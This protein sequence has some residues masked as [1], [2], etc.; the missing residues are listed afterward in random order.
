[1]KS[2]M[3]NRWFAVQIQ[4]V[5]KH[6]SVYFKQLTAFSGGTMGQ[7]LFFFR[8]GRGELPRVI[9]LIFCFQPAK[10]SLSLK[11]Y[12]W[13]NTRGIILVD[14]GVCQ[15]DFGAC[16]KDFGAF[17]CSL[18]LINED[19]LRFLCGPQSQW[20][21]QSKPPVSLDEILFLLPLEVGGQGVIA[22]CF[23]AGVN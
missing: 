11:C 14:F 18:V 19:F 5:P 22:Q 10:W 6:Q 1:M 8:H 12:V 21:F 4:A 9:K 15:K 16:Q 7:F 20:S 23:C 17:L 13:S 2:L 3:Q